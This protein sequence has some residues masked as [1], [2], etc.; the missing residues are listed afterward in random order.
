M[1]VLTEMPTVANVVDSMTRSDS[2]ILQE[3]S[4]K[5]RVEIA[6]VFGDM[7]KEILR[8]RAENEAMRLKLELIRDIMFSAIDSGIR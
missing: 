3:M 4:V 5:M 6:E 8:L 2:D 1:F 7:D